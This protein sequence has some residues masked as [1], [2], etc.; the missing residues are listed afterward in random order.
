MKPVVGDLLRPIF[1]IF[2][3]YGQDQ[4]HTRPIEMSAVQSR[5]VDL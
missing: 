2:V 1:E 4:L 3:G 5:V